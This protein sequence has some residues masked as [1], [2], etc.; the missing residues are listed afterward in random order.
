M[1]FQKEN[2]LE[3]LVV[4]QGH[5]KEAIEYL[6]ESENLRSMAREKSKLV[7]FHFCIKQTST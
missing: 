4:S 1:G 5:L 7:S 3:A 2:A 6:L